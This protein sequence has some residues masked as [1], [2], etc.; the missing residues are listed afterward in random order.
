MGCILLFKVLVHEVFLM[1]WGKPLKL[2]DYSS[3]NYGI[4]SVKQYP[5]D[6]GTRKAWFNLFHKDTFEVL[7]SE[8][9]NI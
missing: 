1:G 7:L 3:I 6:F 5:L 9:I 2:L 8:V 4:F